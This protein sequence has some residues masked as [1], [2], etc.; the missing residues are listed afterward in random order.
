MSKHNIYIY[1]DDPTIKDYTN[2]TKSVASGAIQFALFLESGG[3]GV[4]LYIGHDN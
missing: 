3:G 4:A 1:P 2:T